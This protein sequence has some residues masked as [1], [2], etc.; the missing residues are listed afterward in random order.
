MRILHPSQGLRLVFFLSFR[1][2]ILSFII[3]LLYFIMRILLGKYEKIIT[4]ST[5][6]LKVFF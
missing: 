1:T 4:T 2:Y 6:R 3:E 5:P